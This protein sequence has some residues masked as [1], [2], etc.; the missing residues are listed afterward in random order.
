MS[1]VARP[2]TTATEGRKALPP[3]LSASLSVSLV[4]Q[5][6]REAVTDFATSVVFQL[7]GFKPKSLQQDKS[8]PK[9]TAPRE[10]EG[11]EGSS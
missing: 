10:K 4:L 1:F 7:P 5:V 6:S 8:A 11:G 9:E 3:P 2:I